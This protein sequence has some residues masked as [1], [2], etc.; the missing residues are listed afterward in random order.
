MACALLFFFCTGA[1]ADS[2]CEA[3]NTDGSGR[4]SV[5]CPDGQSAQCTDG[6]GAST[7]TCICSGTNATGKKSDKVAP[8]PLTFASSLDNTNLID[9]VNGKLAQLP[10]HHLSDSCHEE[11]DRTKCT[12]QE[13]CHGGIEHGGGCTEHEVCKMKQVCMPV[14]GHLTVAPPLIVVEGPHVALSTTP[15]DNVPTSTALKTG[16]WNNCSSVE[17]SD[18]FTHSDTFVVGTTVNKTKTIGTGKAETTSVSGKVSFSYAGIGGDVGA[19]K[20]ATVSSSITYSDATTESFTHTTTDT[21]QKMVR[22]PPKAA[23]EYTHYFIQLHVPVPFTGSAVV[24]GQLS[25]N[26]DGLN[27][28]SQVLPTVGDRT[29]PFAGSIVDSN[30]IVTQSETMEAPAVCNGTDVKMTV[31]SSE[32]TASHP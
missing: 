23:V 11:T 31:S 32:A 14:M 5:S 4:C 29:F 3:T 13:T 21:D 22:V 20:T 18:T 8:K 28:L 7:P 10:L 6:T 25:H 15:L 9:V 2:Y 12:I 27:L 17:Q 1:I 24:D 19:S 16:R 26:M 30:Q